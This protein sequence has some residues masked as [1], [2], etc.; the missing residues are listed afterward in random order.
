MNFNPLVKK[1]VVLAPVFCVGAYAGT[2]L[3]DKLV[4]HYFNYIDHE[5]AFDFKI[6]FEERY[7]IFN[8][9]TEYDNSD[10]SLG[11]LKKKVINIVRQGKNAEIASQL[12]LIR[13]IENLYYVDPEDIKKCNSILDLQ[14]LIDSVIP[15]VEVLTP[16]EK[17]NNYQQRLY[18][19]KV[20]VENMK[21]VESEKERLL[22]LPFL[23]QR[24]QQYPEPA[25]GTW[26]YNLFEELFGHPYSYAKEEVETEEKIHKFNYKQFLHPSIIEKYNDD[27][28]NPDFEMYI[29]LKNIDTKTR[30]EQA[31]EQ[32]KFFCMKI[33]PKL[34]LLND[35]EKGRDFAYTLINSK[36]NKSALEKH[37]YENYSNQNEEFLFRQAE[38]ARLINKNNSVVDEVEATTI[39][40]KYRNGIRAEE[41]RE[42]LTNPQ[43][44]NAMQ[45]ALKAKFKYSTP[46]SKYEAAKIQRNQ[47]TFVD[48][49]IEEGLDLNDPEVNNI[50]NL[51]KKTFD[52][53][54][55][56]ELEEHANILQNNINYPNNSFPNGKTK[57]PRYFQY[58]PKLD[59]SDYQP[60]IPNYGYASFKDNR[61]QYRQEEAKQK[62]IDEHTISFNFAE[63][64]EKQGFFVPHLERENDDAQ[65]FIFKKRPLLMTQERDN[66]YKTDMTRIDEFVNKQV[67]QDVSLAGNDITE[68]EMNQAIFEAQYVKPIEETE[69]FRRLGKRTK[70]EVEGLFRAIN[71]RA[72]PYFNYNPNL[73][74]RNTNRRPEIDIYQRNDPLHKLVSEV[75]QPTILRRVLKSW[76]SGSEI[77]SKLPYY[78]ET[79]KPEKYF[80]L[81]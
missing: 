25:K 61:Y 67:E 54:D 60:D 18:K 43:K 66:L 40:P 46:L 16:E 6:N 3:W 77:R 5:I 62:F 53:P 51:F 71:L 76:R 4:G 12:S 31:K 52:N 17:I 29:K 22:G 47:L 26:Q 48:T 10:F 23:K 38:E 78:P 73:E 33:L 21:I 2:R 69:E 9:G 8:K 59:F 80:S 49:A 56:T 44:K 58:E 50:D 74:F 28:E 19:Y 57:H 7:K 41:L 37:F 64:A 39:K 65:D 63:S 36:E 24:L 15:K 13:N 45:K 68:E 70:E 14:V 27:P 81:I 75:E 11:N 55:L 30:L 79:K 72:D 32:R 1:K 35:E 34:N 20:G 42:I